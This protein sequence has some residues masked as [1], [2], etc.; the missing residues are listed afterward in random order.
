MLGV[1]LS[2]DTNI[3]SSAVVWMI[4]GVDGMIRVIYLVY[5]KRMSQVLEEGHASH[6]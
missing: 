1:A 2:M 5:I 6:V 3:L 4:T